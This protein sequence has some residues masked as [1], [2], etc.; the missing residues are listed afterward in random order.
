V[1][2]ALRLGLGGYFARSELPVGALT[3]HDTGELLR[4]A[5]LAAG[6]V[7]ESEFKGTVR[8]P[9]GGRLK[10][11]WVWFA[12]QDRRRPIVAIEIEGRDVDQKSINADRAKFGDCGAAVRA[13]VL[14][15]VDHDLS[16]KGKPSRS[17]DPVERARTL[18]G[19]PEVEVLRDIDL[20]KPGGIDGLQTR[21]RQALAKRM[22]SPG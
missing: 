7:V 13:L 19:L 4:R 9:G 16:P 15:Q 14:F 5:G 18:L 12:P 10:V 20:T 17:A 1:S 8:G 22:G 11:D 3:Q 21:A 6:F 2:D